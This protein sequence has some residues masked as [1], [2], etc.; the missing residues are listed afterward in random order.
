LKSQCG[1]TPAGIASKFICKTRGFCWFWLCSVRQ[2]VLQ[3]VSNHLQRFQRVTSRY[4]SLHATP[5]KHRNSRFVHRTD[6]AAEMLRWERIALDQSA[7]CETADARAAYKAMA[8]NYRGE[9]N[10]GVGPR[11]AHTWGELIAVAAY[12]A[13]A[14]GGNLAFFFWG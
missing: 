14:I 7:E 13:V 1:D 5:E 10:K 12:F 6:A 9:A 8:E 3:G 11:R 2:A 4:Q